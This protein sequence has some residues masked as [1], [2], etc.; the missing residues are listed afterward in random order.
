[1]HSGKVEP[2]EPTS[3]NVLMHQRLRHIAPTDTF[4]SICFEPRSASRGGL[5]FSFTSVCDVYFWP[6]A[7]YFIFE[8][9]R[10]VLCPA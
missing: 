1:M 7:D 9:F 4:P 2:N 6:K 10:R 8:V 5:S 3:I